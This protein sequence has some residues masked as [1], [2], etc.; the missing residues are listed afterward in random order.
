MPHIWVWLVK[1]RNMMV[2]PLMLGEIFVMCVYTY[3][4]SRLYVWHTTGRFRSV[5]WLMHTCVHACVHASQ[6]C[7]RGIWHSRNTLDC[8]FTECGP[9][10]L[11]HIHSATHTA[12]HTLHHT[13][14]ITHAAPHTLH[15]KLQSTL[16]HCSTQAGRGICDLHNTHTDASCHTYEWVKSHIWMR[17]VTDTKSESCHGSENVMSHIQMHLVTHIVKEYISNG[18]MRAKVQLI[19]DRMA[20]NLE[21]IAKTFPTIQNS[22][23]GIHD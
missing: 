19:A 11:H 4:M 12:P 14:W 16:Q 17:R 5:P 22:A 18:E 9:H 10:T 21:N 13:Q 3:S 23:H 6:R 20:L 15:H 1:N 2:E 8:M 7:W